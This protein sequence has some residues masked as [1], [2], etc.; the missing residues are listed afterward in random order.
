MPALA[1]AQC[2]LGAAQAHGR[3]SLAGAMQE[4]SFQAAAPTPPPTRP[5]G[6]ETP[7]TH[8]GQPVRQVRAPPPCT[9]SPVLLK[10][11]AA[12]RQ[13]LGAGRAH[14]CWCPFFVRTK[15]IL[16]LSAAG[17][18]EGISACA[19][20][21]VSVQLT[22]RAS[23][24]QPSLHAQPGTCDARRC[25]R[26]RRISWRPCPLGPAG[27]ASAQRAQRPTA[28]GRRCA[29]VG[30]ADACA[31]VRAIRGPSF[32]CRM[33]SALYCSCQGSRK[34]R[35]VPATPDKCCSHTLAHKAQTAPGLSSPACCC[36]PQDCAL[37]DGHPMRQMHRAWTQ[38]QRSG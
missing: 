14:L 29:A 3:P 10:P 35:E 12:L 18:G 26:G 33:L 38:R 7:G 27:S 15:P 9:P 6:V 20:L 19:A 32:T 2:V 16:S 22:E 1:S 34:R 23:G 13:C 4:G 21:P 31:P 28:P 30:A 8:E 11:G 17:M 36:C 5:P 25:P 37:H 24:M